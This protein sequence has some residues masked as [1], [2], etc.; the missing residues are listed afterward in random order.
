[1]NEERVDAVLRRAL[2][3]TPA[4]AARV[5]ESALSRGERT[6]PGRVLAIAFTSLVAVGLLATAV[7]R[8]H[9]VSPGRAAEVYSVDGLIVGVSSTGDTWIVGPDAGAGTDQPR[10]IVMK[11]EAR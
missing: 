4:D 8:P 2:S 11:G 7:L 5:A 3:P 10:M 1:M 6:S 9:P